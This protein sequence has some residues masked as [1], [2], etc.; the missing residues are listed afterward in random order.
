MGVQDDMN[1]IELYKCRLQQMLDKVFDEQRENLEEVAARLCDCVTSGRFLYIFGTGH[2]HI[3]AEE[4]FYRAGGL[5]AVIP[6]L[7]DELMLHVSAS[8]STILE[9]QTGYAAKLLEKYNLGSG[10]MLIVCSNSGRNAVPVEMAIEARKRGAFVVA[11]TNVRH[12]QSCTPRNALNLRL[13]EVADMVLDNGGCIGDASIDVGFAYKVGATS[14]AVCAA[15]L[16]AIGSRC[17]ELAVQSHREID[18]F[19][20]S[21]VDNGDAINE[22]ILQKYKPLIDKL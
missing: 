13:M 8:G 15:M 16:Q 2:A 19:S 12:S 1:A 7:D 14:T 5:A 21:N 3:L 11:L 6:I 4:M 17:V 20:S 10:D 18:V 22:R 9:R